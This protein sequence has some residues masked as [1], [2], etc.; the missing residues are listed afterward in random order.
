MIFFLIR[1]A[2]KPNRAALFCDSGYNMS[3]FHLGPRL[4]ALTI[5]I[6]F[7]FICNVSNLA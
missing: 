3:F 2:V 5:K 6:E 4:K 7:S 1:I